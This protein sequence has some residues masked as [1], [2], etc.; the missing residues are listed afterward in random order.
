MKF[1]SLSINENIKKALLENSFFDATE[2]QEK[3]ID[4]ILNQ[5][6]LLA[7]SQT[8]SGK[9]LAYALPI[10][11][12]SET[13]IKYP[14]SLVVCPTR[15]LA[16][17]ICDEFRK[18]TKYMEG[19]KAVPIYGG[20]DINRQI[21]ALKRGAAVVV[22]TP[23]RIIDHLNRKTLK[24]H[25]I[26]TLVLDEADEMLNMGFKEDIE[27]ILKS[28][29][30]KKQVL[31]FSATYPAN[32]K[33]LANTFMSNP[34][35]I[36]IG[37]SNKSIKQINQLFA[38]VGKTQKQ[39]A[40]INILNKYKPKTSIIFCNT[41]KMCEELG[42]FLNKENFFASVIHGDLRQ[43]ERKRVMDSIKTNKSNLL[44]ATDV[45][46]RGIDI[47]DVDYVINYDLPNN[48][49]YLIHRMGRTARAGKSGNS[50]TI[51]NTPAQL[52]LL[53][54]YN[55]ETESDSKEIDLGA[56]F[57]QRLTTLNNASGRTHS[58]KT[59]T[60]SKTRVQLKNKPFEKFGKTGNK[61]FNKKESF[62]KKEGFNKKENFNKFDRN[63]KIS[64]KQE[65]KNTENKKLDIF[66]EFDYFEDEIRFSKKDYKKEK[67]GAAVTKPIFKEKNS[68]FSA[69]SRNRFE[70]P[71]KSARFGKFDKPSA[72]NRPKTNRFK[73]EEGVKTDNTKSLA[74]S[75]E[76]KKFDKQERPARFGRSDKPA[77]FGRPRTSRFEKEEGA[78]S[79]SIKTF[80]ESG[81]RKVYE[82]SSRFE[83]SKSFRGAGKSNFVTKDKKPFNKKFSSNKK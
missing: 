66:E 67:A 59:E 31:M 27:D 42:E 41:K 20:S 21:Q 29:P 63:K 71:E 4:L 15:E 7:R 52:K 18:I 23:G 33:I 61:D 28:A 69:P 82:K 64:G 24:I 56:D 74:E 30:Q 73:K 44:V 53:Q 2:I 32:I 72:F 11:E 25:N 83:K 43:S 22:G 40:L 48:V 39:A 62:N 19:I 37:S 80:A 26:K 47:N 38:F 49:E 35:H 34:V 65:I 14:Q 68:K 46:A 81:E 17:Q 54:Q 9:T 13:G 45:A 51:I 36:E 77:S 76:R 3:T 16:L 75:G 12:K 57:V 10:I 70:K 79:D 8:G 60:S 55:R 6:D 78:K 58:I 50:I 5:K 1:S